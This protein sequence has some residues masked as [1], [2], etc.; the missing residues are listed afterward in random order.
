[1]LLQDD[2]EDLPVY[3]VQ[4]L[5]VHLEQ[6]QGLARHLRRDA[7]LMAHLCEIPDALEQAV[8]YTRRP[9]RAQGY[10]AR[11][12]LLD[13][14]IQ[15]VGGTMHD[16]EQL[17]HRV[18]VKAMREPEPVS[19][20][21]GDETRPRRGPDQREVRQFQADAAGAGSLTQ[22]DVD[23][24]ILHRRVEDLL[25]GS[26]ETVDLVDEQHVSELQ[27]RED[28]GHVGLALKGR[29]G[30]GH[31]ADT[32][33]R[34]DDVGQRGLAQSRRPGE[35]DVVQRLPARERG[36]DEDLKLLSQHGLPDEGVQ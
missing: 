32:H 3:P 6:V 28:G 29:P 27:V 7:A 16:H 33:L 17:V 10:L 9:A 22:D 12:L 25:D 2:S 5:G 1:M 35:Q 20:R 13:D 15:Y 8:G 26:V 18:V 34:R 21:R 31:D 36:L 11:P 30:R 4:T 19:Q 14:H 23:L 24:E